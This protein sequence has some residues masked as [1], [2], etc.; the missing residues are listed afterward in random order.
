MSGTKW[1]LCPIC[2][3]NQRGDLEEHTNQWYQKL[4]IN[5]VSAVIF[6]MS[7]FSDMSL[8]TF[9]RAVSIE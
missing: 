4:E 8:G 3:T 1:V 2:H 5:S 9:S 6:P 7:M